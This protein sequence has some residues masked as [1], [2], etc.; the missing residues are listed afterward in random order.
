MARTERVLASESHDAMVEEPKVELTLATKD[1]RHYVAADSIFR[2]VGARDP[3]AFWKS[4]PYLLHFMHGYKFN[5]QLNEALQSSPEKIGKL[6]RHH[7]DSVLNEADL[8]AW[9]ELDAGNAK[10]RELA[11]DLLDGGLWQLLWMPP[12]V[13][14]WPLEGAFE[15]QDAC[16]KTLLF[17]AWNVVPDVVSAVLSFEAER[18]NDWTGKQALIPIPLNSKCRNFVFHKR[19]QARAP[20]IACYSCC[21]LVASWLMKRIHL[22]RLLAS[23]AVLGFRDR[24]EAMLADPSLPNPQHGDVDSRWEWAV[25][26]LLDPSLR[27]FVTTWYNEASLPKPNPEVLPAY[28]EDLLQVDPATLG[29][30]PKGLIDLLTD[31]AIGSPATLAARTLASSHIPDIDRCCG[32]LKIADGFWR[33]FNRPAVISLL[34]RLFPDN[35][36]E[37][38]DQSFYWRLVLRYCIDGNLQAVLDESWHLLWEQHDWAQGQS[39]V[40]T[41]AMCVE[42]LADVVY[43]SPSRVHANFYRQNGSKVNKSEIRIRTVLALRFGAT[44]SEEREV[45]QDAVRAAFNSPFRPFVLTST[46]IGQEGL[47]FHPWCHRIVHWDLPGNPVDLEQREGPGSPL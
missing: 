44:S 5:G 39:R 6:L 13:P 1:I 18:P 43:P 38:R 34:K 40:E 37:P 46:S 21:Y 25:P 14:Y 23:T 30:R 27:E 11:C 22:R 15:G 20:A 19:R 35:Q 29:R 7:S 31:V 8:N 26:V 17:S 10:L 16:T 24:I 4:A 36:K 9:G 41:A 45:T 28:L 42:K 12:T 32:A 3:I 47:D 33:V 2:A